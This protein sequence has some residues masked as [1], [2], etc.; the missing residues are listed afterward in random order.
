[1]KRSGQLKRTSMPP[2]TV[3]LQRTG[4]GLTRRTPIKTVAK[5]RRPRDTGPP[6]RTR[7]VVHQRSGGLCEWPGCW[8]EATDVQHR[9]GRKIGGRRGVMRERLNGVAWL[10]HCCRIH[11]DLV[12]DAVGIVR[13]IAWIAG[14]LLEEHQDATVTPVLIRQTWPVPVLLDND[15]DWDQIN[16]PPTLA[17]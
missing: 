6:A 1:M 16:D 7:K 9:L 11:H 14:W 2:R 13:L 15:G 12:T 8:R 5:P 3:P 4:T 17:A 10:L